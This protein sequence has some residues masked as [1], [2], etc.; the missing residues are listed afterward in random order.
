MV[1]F[2]NGMKKSRISVS[3]KRSPLLLVGMRAP[4]NCAASSAASRRSEVR[5]GKSTPSK[6]GLC[7]CLEPAVAVRSTKS[8]TNAFF[9]VNRA[10]VA[11]GLV[12]GGVAA[13]LDWAATSFEAVHQDNDQDDRASS[14]PWWLSPPPGG[15]LPGPYLSRGVVASRVV[16]GK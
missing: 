12:T 3:H 16:E 13:D 10:P 4:Y 11:A 15:R 6:D 8:T 7:S 5:A 9:V 14:L 2:R 1:V